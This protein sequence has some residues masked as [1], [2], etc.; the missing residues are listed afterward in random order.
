[1]LPG[2]GVG[3]GF[4]VGIKL[5]RKFEGNYPEFKMSL[6]PF[7]FFVCVCVCFPANLINSSRRC[8][9]QM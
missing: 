5:K 3:T 7:L 2:A 4:L 6:I 9:F 1:M 8:K